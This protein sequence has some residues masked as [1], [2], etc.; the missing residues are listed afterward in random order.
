V[1][2]GEDHMEFVAE[3]VVGTVR[4]VAELVREVLAGGQR[5]ELV[6]G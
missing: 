3:G 6:G 1:G 4:T 2:A 5:E